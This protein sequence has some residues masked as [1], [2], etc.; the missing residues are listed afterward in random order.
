MSEQKMVFSTFSNISKSDAVD[1]GMSPVDVYEDAHFWS[2]D[3]AT[4][5]EA[6][7]IAMIA[8][9]QKMGIQKYGTTVSENP[10]SLREWLHHALEESLDMAVYLM[11]T[12]E[13]LDKIQDDMK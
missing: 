9:R 12:I 4:G 2:A 13:E 6:R 1:S 5:T 7:V 10:L 3:G 8:E 11:R